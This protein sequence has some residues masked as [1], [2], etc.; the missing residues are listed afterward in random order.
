MKK[1][2]LL[3]S[4]GLDSAT[5]GLIA[6]DMGFELHALSFSYGQR[7]G[8]EL[9]AAQ[10]VAAFIGVCGHRI[11]HIDLAALGGSAL[12]S[13]DI[14]VPKDG[15]GTGI[16]VT[17]VPARN[18]IF[19]SYAVACA[20]ALG[21][22]SDIFIGVN[23]V[24]YSGYPDCRPEFISA[25]QK[26]ANLATAAGVSGRELTIHAPLMRLTKSEI[27]KTGVKAG[28]DYAITHSCY[29]PDP[30]TGAAC[31][32]CDSCRIRKK[33]FEDAGITDPTLYSA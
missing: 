27:I 11:A 15:A 30:Q 2:I 31:G 16:P 26:M 21:E 32:R 1:A 12:T 9:L 5:C 28:M 25:F 7:H 14:D 20:E 24:D 4:G 17:Y 33:G 19:L 29:D 3:L 23:S 10:R 8:C 13:S 22:C 18:L 6:R